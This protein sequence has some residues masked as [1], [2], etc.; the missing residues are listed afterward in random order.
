MKHALQEDALLLLL[1]YAVNTFTGDRVQEKSGDESLRHFLTLYANL[2]YYL[3]PFA[4][5][6]DSCTLRQVGETVLGLMA[7]SHTHTHTH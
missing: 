7:V 5:D 6:G 2:F 1:F 3:L 4:L